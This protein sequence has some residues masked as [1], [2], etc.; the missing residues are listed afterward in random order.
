MGHYRDIEGLL[1]H[2]TGSNILI[3]DTN[4]IQFYYQF[5]ALLPQSQI[6]SPYDLVLI[7][8]WVHAEYA[9]HDGKSAYISA[10]PV[11]MIIVDEVNDYLPMLGYS[12]HKLMELFRT[13]SQCTESHK[14]FNFLRKLQ[15]E[16]YPDDWID[17]FYDQGFP[18]K[19]TGGKITKKNAGEV[20]ILTL[21]FA[22][23][24]HYPTQITSISLA[25]SDHGIITLKNKILKEANQAP[26]E[27][28]TS[29]TPPIS[30]LSTDVSIYNAIKSNIIRPDQIP[31][32]RT[33]SKSSIYIEHFADGSSNLNECVVDT[34]MFIE[35]CKC[36]QKF[37]I[38][39]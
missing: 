21:S 9:H 5:S 37:T 36:P 27:L 15:V 23:L 17:Q 24:S 31:L 39:F 12:D 11:P 1:R 10:I 29:K 7:P 2:K 34:P 28:H 4:N 8:G 25:S 13:I 35:I 33:N 26:L 16:N 32:L 20:S 38:V 22:L 18:T 19:N 3:L 14:F 6:F 30:F